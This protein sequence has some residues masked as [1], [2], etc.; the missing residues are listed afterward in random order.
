M[1]EDQDLF[2]SLERVV[3]PILAWGVGNSPIEVVVCE[4]TKVNVKKT[5]LELFL[6]ESGSIHDCQR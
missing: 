2:R 1:V 4:D 3:G 5:S 6:L